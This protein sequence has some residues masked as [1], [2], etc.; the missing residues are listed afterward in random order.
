MVLP[1]RDDNPTRRPAVVTILVIIACVGIYAFWQPHDERSEMAFLV[2]HAAIPCEVTSGAPLDLAQLQTGVCDPPARLALQGGAAEPFPD[3]QVWLAVIVSTFLHGG[4]FHLL[5]NMLFLWIFG[6]NVEDRVGP[7]GFALLYLVCGVFAFAVHIVGNADSLTPVVG[8]SGAIAGVMG[9]YLIWFPRSRVLT[10][11][12]PFF[13]LPLPAFAVL[14]LWFA[15]QFLT[16]EASGV[17][18]LAHVGGF[19]AGVVIAL[20]INGFTG[21]RPAPVRE[22]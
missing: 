4:I 10:F 21:T 12:P 17:A 8:A 7:I 9:A 14:G 16:D 18:W 2:E 19:V 22:G 3:K 6:N 15:M 20:I 1:L 13:I 5:G 11:I